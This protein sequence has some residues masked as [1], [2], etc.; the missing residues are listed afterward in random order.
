M[1]KLDQKKYA[2][3][4]LLALMLEQFF[5]HKLAMISFFIIIFLVVIALMAPQISHWTNL[6]PSTQNVFQRY[7]KP[8]SKIK[9]SEEEKKRQM[10]QFIEENPEL[11]EKIVKKLK[12]LNTSLPKASHK[13]LLLSFFEKLEDPSFY[14]TIKNE[15]MLKPL[16]KIQRN[17]H[18]LHILGTDELGRDV[19]IRLIYGTRVSISVGLAV[20]LF[21]ALF[22]LFIGI[23]SGLSKSFLDSLLMR[24]TDVF[25]SI[26]QIPLLIFISAIDLGK[27]IN[28]SGAGENE[29]VYKMIFILCLFSWMTVARIVRSEVLTLKQRDF[30]LVA[31]TLGANPF[32]ILIYHVIPNV[33]APL[34]VAVTLSI[35]QVILSEAALSFLG[36]GIQ[37]P[38]P[39]WGRMLFNAQELIYEAPFLAI[40]PGLMIL[41]VVICFNF[42]GDGLQNALNPKAL[43]R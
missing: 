35:G 32:H 31:K 13:E 18:K 14:K 23:V 15:P 4:S 5:A 34:V 37:P 41:I 39:S 3:K 2:S 9:V 33:L 10:D 25:L 30:I 21:S 12:N 24:F 20:A 11:S 16:I 40:F 6:N 38:T 28:I 1:K 22:G 43:K 7:E 19:F 17:F 36:L 26:P 42:L 8:F 27:I 29:S